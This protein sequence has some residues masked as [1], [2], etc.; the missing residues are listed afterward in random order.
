M[1][2]LA[3]SPWAKQPGIVGLTLQSKIAPLQDKLIQYI[4]PLQLVNKSYLCNW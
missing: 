3:H 2:I 4:I 1:C